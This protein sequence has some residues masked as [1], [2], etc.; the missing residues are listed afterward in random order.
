MRCEMKVSILVDTCGFMVLMY[1]IYGM[2]LG[3]SAEKEEKRMA[4]LVLKNHMSRV[5]VQGTESRKNNGGVGIEVEKAGVLGPIWCKG[6]SHQ[7]AG[8]SQGRTGRTTSRRR[9]MQGDEG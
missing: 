2:S 5:L 6:R 8:H 3:L 4:R 9:G 7:R 1:L